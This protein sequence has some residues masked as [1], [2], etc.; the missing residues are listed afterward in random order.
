MTAI[1][2]VLNPFA[3]VQKANDAKR[4]SDLSQVGKALETYYQDNG[5]YPAHSSSYTIIGLDGNPA[6]WD[7]QFS[8]YMSKLPKDPKGF[9]KYV[10]FASSNGQSFWLYASLERGKDKEGN[11]LDPQLCNRGNPCV[12]LA[13]SANNIPDTA[14]GGTCNYAVTSS[15]VSP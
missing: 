2:L 12:S 13:P 1:L 7:T 8:P 14:C 11:P 4:K 3:Q 6:D 15:N 9:Y 10:Y 5:K